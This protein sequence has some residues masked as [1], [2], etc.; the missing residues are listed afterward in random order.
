MGLCSCTLNPCNWFV[1]LHKNSYID[2]D[3]TFYFIC[4][5]VGY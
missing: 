5:C 4:L 3:P 1:V 2:V